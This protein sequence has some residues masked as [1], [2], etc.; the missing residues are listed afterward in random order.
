MNT[1]KQQ[2]HKAIRDRARR[3]LADLY[4]NATPSYPRLDDD[5]A[6]RFQSWFEDA[7]RYA[8]EYIKDGGAN[9]GN[10][11]E[12]L[13][14]PA[15]AGR[16]RSPAARAYYV[17]MRMRALREEREDCGA[18][19]GWDVVELAAGNKTREKVLRRLFQKRPFSRNNARWERIGEYGTL[20]QWGRGGRTLAPDDLIKQGGG[21][22][23]S[24][25]ED[26]ADE[27]PIRA[28]IELIRVV[29]SFNA[30][31]AAWCASV[32]EQWAE[33][34]R[35]RISEE[36]AE[37]KRARDAKR[38]AQVLRDRCELYAG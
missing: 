29:E 3:A 25:R 11:R 10:Y 9:P 36:R 18:F 6:A 8:I 12:I 16:Y 26:Y 24:I 21:S 23:F 13:E 2:Q 22:S 4:H 32:P 27:L 1:R 20:Y 35:E 19:T 5:D 30:Y 33:I 15:N 37:K 7:A 28:V 31:V 38:A 14:H 34:E 17:Q